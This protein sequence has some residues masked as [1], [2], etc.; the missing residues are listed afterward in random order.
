VIGLAANV[1]VGKI[2]VSKNGDW[3][4][5]ACGVVFEDGKIKEGVYCCFSGADYSLRYT[6]KDFKY[7]VPSPDVW[8]GQAPGVQHAPINHH[9]IPL[10]RLM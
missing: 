8:R 7:T 4:Q 10:F 1:D 5:E 6:F 3:S 9:F 2:A